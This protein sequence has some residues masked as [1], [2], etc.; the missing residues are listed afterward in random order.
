MDRNSGN[1]IADSI[2]ESQ[3]LPKGKPPG[4]EVDGM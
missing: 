3:L 2:K 1:K 4:T